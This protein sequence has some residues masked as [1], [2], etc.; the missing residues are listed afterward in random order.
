MKKLLQ[1]CSCFEL[2][3][4]QKKVPMYITYMSR[5]TLSSNLNQH[6]M[7]PFLKCDFCIFPNIAR[8]LGS[9][10]GHSTALSSASDVASGLG[11]L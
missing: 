1:V 11:V 8:L 7:T 4:G 10:A 5:F 6:M 9:L 3:Y 2:V